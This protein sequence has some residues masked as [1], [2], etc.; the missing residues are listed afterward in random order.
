[1][2]SYKARGDAMRLVQWRLRVSS[3]REQELGDGSGESP[4][5]NKGMEAWEGPVCAGSSKQLNVTEESVT[6]S[7]KGMFWC[8]QVPERICCCDIGP[9]SALAGWAEREP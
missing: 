4:G 9:L 2:E 3:V 6:L 8:P 5:R 1:M 7:V